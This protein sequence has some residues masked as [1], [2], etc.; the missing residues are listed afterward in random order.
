MSGRRSQSRLGL[1]L[2]PPHAGAA[3]PPQPQAQYRSARQRHRLPCHGP[4]AAAPMP[5]PAAGPP[6]GAAP[7]PEYAPPPAPPAEEARRAEWT[8]P[9]PQ[10]DAEFEVDTESC[11]AGGGDQRR[12]HGVSGS[13]KSRRQLFARLTR[14]GGTPA[15]AAS[16]RRRRRARRRRSPRPIWPTGRSGEAALACRSGAEASAIRNR[17]GLP[18]RRSSASPRHHRLGCT[19]PAVVALVLRTVPVRAVDP[20]CRFCRAVLLDARH[21]GRPTNLAFQDV[22][23]DWTNDGGQIV[24]EVQGD[25]RQ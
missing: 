6:I 15:A 25:V 7:R 16:P 17:R 12:G 11:R 2:R 20:W 3:M 4:H 1:R 14:K 19:C 22:R 24:L 9:P 23:Y 21:V 10:A 13:R 8:P 5:Q 18:A